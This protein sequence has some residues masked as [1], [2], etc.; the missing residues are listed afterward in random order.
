MI[1]IYILEWSNGKKYIGQSNNIPKRIKQHF[2]DMNGVHKNKRIR[3]CV[4]SCGY[5]SW[6]VL[7][8]CSLDS[9]NAAEIRWI[10]AYDTYRNGC[11]LTIGGG[12]A[13]KGVSRNPSIP[14]PIGSWPVR[15]SIATLIL[16]FALLAYYCWPLAIILGLIICLR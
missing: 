15:I 3:A 16:V 10:R 7:E 6:R 4:A 2:E 8:E 9:L 12:Y 13:R 5:P 11:N 14:A 1:G